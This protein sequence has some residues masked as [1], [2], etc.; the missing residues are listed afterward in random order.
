MMS[1]TQTSVPGAVSGLAFLFTV[2]L[3]AGCTDDPLLS[4]HQGS[5]ATVDAA[6]NPASD[7]GRA[8]NPGVTVQTADVF[9]QGPEGPV[10]SEH[11]A[12]IRRSPDGIS[13]KLSMP[14]PEPDTYTYPE[15]GVAFS[16]PGHPE[17]FTLW[18]FVFN[19]PEACSPPGC[20]GSDVGDTDAEGGAFFVAGHLV[21]GPRLTLSGY[22]SERTEPFG[23]FPLTNP[24]GAEVHLAVAPH[25]GLEPDLLPEAIR[26]PTGPGPDI[27][28]LALFP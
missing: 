9:G 11:G 2:T 13:M 24:A 21:G 26:T 8:G 5:D 14:T 4:P 7:Q 27:W 3:L 23:G 12:T 19:N 17:A 25:G 6:A 1:R 22:V 28:W 18:G 10:V 15:E 20:D 16:G